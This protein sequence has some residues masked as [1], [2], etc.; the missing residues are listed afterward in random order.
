MTA[1]AWQTIKLGGAAL[2]Y[3]LAGPADAPKIA[4]LH[5]AT[6]GVTPYCGGAHVWGASLDPFIAG[7]RV[8]A[9]D[10][11][12][13]GGSFVPGAGLPTVQIMVRQAAALLEALAFRPCHVV[14]H[15]LGGLVALALA[16]EAPALVGSL[17]VVASAA[18][19]P[20]GDM[21]PNLALA[22]PPPP[23]WSRASQRWALERLSYS[24]HHVDDALLDACVAAADGAPHRAAAAALAGPAARRLFAPGIAAAKSRFFEQCRSDGMPVPVQ[25]VWATHDP[26]TTREHG[27]WVFRLAAQRQT[28]AQFHLVNRA[29]SLLFREEPEQFHA[30]VASF[31]DG[32]RRGH[33][34]G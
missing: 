6:P 23:P 1:L 16:C 28:A 31:Q 15:D 12:G 30:I 20:A 25:V 29:G 33:N 3:A 11:P 18:S 19:A 34:S 26:L 10:L 4:F 9:L 32:L 14:G 13:S 27:L 2:R 24:R 7:R 21:V 5:G 22:Y 8:L 17:S